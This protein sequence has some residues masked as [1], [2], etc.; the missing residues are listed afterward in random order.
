LTNQKKRILEKL[1]IR[2]DYEQNHDF[3]SC[4]TSGCGRFSFGEA[5]EHVFRCAKCG[6]SLTHSDNKRIVEF[7]SKKTE[8]LKNELKK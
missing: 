7:L 5:I 1:K 2:L 4:H 6:K 8:Q 3:Y